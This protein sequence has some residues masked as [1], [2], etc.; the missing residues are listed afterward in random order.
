MHRPANF[1]AL[2]TLDVILGEEWEELV[3]PLEPSE[4]AEPS[5][6]EVREDSRR[7]SF[8]DMIGDSIGEGLENLGNLFKP[9]DERT[10][11]RRASHEDTTPPAAPPT[12]GAMGTPST[13]TMTERATSCMRLSAGAPRRLSARS[14]GP[15]T[16]A[17]CAVL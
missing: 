8:L 12:M 10:S 15:R 3:V 7:K 1:E 11:S 6:V 9:E 17:H 4:E 13:S 5:G 2:V 16:S 14:I